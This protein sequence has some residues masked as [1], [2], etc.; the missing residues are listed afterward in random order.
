MAFT[1][2]MLQN[3][4]PTITLNHHPYINYWAEAKEKDIYKYVLTIL[5]KYK[6]DSLDIT[7]LFLFFQV[8]NI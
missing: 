3:K 6:T 1:E 4:E 5:R 7:I 2:I 8:I